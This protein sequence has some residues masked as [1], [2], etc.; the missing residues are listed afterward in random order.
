MPTILISTAEL[1]ASDAAAC[2]GP[3]LMRLQPGIRLLAFGSPDLAKNG[4]TVLA[5]P[6]T[7]ASIGHFD[8]LARAGSRRRLLRR[9]LRL[10]IEDPPDLVLAIDSPDF[11][12][13]LAKALRHHTIP[14]VWYIPPQEY[15]WGAKGLA[16]QIAR[17]SRR[18]LTLDAAA[19]RMYT[20][21]GAACTLTGHSLANPSRPLSQP[22][23]PDPLIALFPG[24]RKQEMQR[25]AP[26]MLAGAALIL[27]EYPN[28][29]FALPL[30]NETYRDQI[31]RLA[32]EQGLP[33]DILPR[34][35]ARS[36]LSKADLVITKAG[37]TTMEAAL[38]GC[39]M[40]VVYR[41]HPLTFWIATR[42][43]RIQRHLPGI[44][45]PNMALGSRSVPELIQNECTPTAIASA[46]RR[47]LADPAASREVLARAAAVMSQP[48]AVTKTARAVLECL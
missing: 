1:S 26:V 17:L 13:P 19:T 41:I 3:E 34:D 35:Q 21:L 10:I 6:T 14:L 28:A 22:A 25:I 29:R 2:L 45:L 27:R 20:S 46:A 18:V 47:I 4:F 32:R 16:R 30:A 24:S 8:A 43:L 38:A 7:A 39:P 40:I 12:L 15:L 44:S 9:C 11:N 48:N 5:D 33:L 42:I 36:L 23:N 31:S 37:T